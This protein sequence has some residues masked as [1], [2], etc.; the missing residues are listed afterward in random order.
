MAGWEVVRRA[1]ALALC[2]A[3][4]SA[5]ADGWHAGPEGVCVEAGR[6]AAS[7]RKAVGES[8]AVGAVVAVDKCR[9]ESA[10]LQ[11]GV[12]ARLGDYT[13]LHRPLGRQQRGVG[14][15]ARPSAAL[16]R[17]C[18]WPWPAACATACRA[19]A[20]GSAAARPSPHHP[21]LATAM[22]HWLWSLSAG[23]A[24]LPDGSHPEL[25]H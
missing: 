13:R 19:D 24:V 15:R 16:E 21:S 20:A 22:F 17:A 6:C 2:A 4:P 11:C 12:L 25:R 9:D 23:P 14:R 10:H 1:E 18:G 7:G 3:G 8:T 5:A